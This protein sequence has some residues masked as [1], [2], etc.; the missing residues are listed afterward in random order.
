[1]ITANQ[2]AQAPDHRAAITQPFLQS[3]RLCC[4]LLQYLTHK[5][6]GLQLMQ[7]WSY[8]LRLRRDARY[9]TLRALPGIPQKDVLNCLSQSMH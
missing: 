3:H 4:F 2:Q 6:F 8:A 7:C 9:A 1:M 5:V